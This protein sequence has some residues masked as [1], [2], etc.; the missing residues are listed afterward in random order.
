MNS[1]R[2]YRVFR[3]SHFLS[4]FSC[5]S[6]HS[7]FYK[8]G[9]SLSAHPVPLRSFCTSQGRS[10]VYTLLY[11]VL[12]DANFTFP[13]RPKPS[14]RPAAQTPTEPVNRESNALR[15]SVLDV[16]L[17]LGIAANGGVA[18]WMFNN[19]LEEED[20]DED[21]VTSMRAPLSATSEEYAAYSTP[22]T[23]ISSH[24]EHH[25]NVVAP[26]LQSEEATANAARPAHIHFPPMPPVASTP[27]QANKLRKRR[28]DGYE[29]DGGY[30]SDG[31]K[32]ARARTK[33][34]KNQKDPGPVVPP[35]SEP[36]EMVPLTKEERKR[37][38]KAAKPSSKDHDAPAE[39]DRED[40]PPKP[41]KSKAPP[42][43][44]KKKSSGDAAAGYETDDGYVSSSGKPKSK[45][46]SRFFSLR[47]AKADPAPEPTVVEPVPPMPERELFPLPIAERF[48]TTLGNSSAAP[49]RSTTPLLPPSQPFA[50]TTSSS[51]SASLSSSSNSLLT[52]GDQDS[53]GTGLL[54]FNAN[55][56]RPFED[57]QSVRS[58]H[59]PD[60]SFNSAITVT[61]A[62]YQQDQA[63]S[64]SKFMIS[65]PLT[66]EP[67][68]PSPL[69]SQAGPR[70]TRPVKAKHIPSPI[71]LSPHPSNHLHPGLGSRAPSPSPVGSPF[72]V[73]T[74]INTTG[75]PNGSARAVSPAPSSVVVAS[76]DY[77]VPSRAPS[78]LLPS[79]NVLSS[80]NVLAYYDI[81]PPSPPPN[82]PLPRPPHAPPSATRDLGGLPRLRGLSQ[83]RGGRLAQD[84]PSPMSAGPSPLS[85][86]PSPGSA[87]V[88]RG[89]AAPF[90]TRPVG[91]PRAGTGHVGPG[92]EARAKV[93]RYRDLYAIQIP[94][95]PVRGGGSARPRYDDDEEA[96]V[97]IRVE[98]YDDADE[99]REEMLGVLDRFHEPRDEPERAGSALG[100]ND[101]GVLR[102]KKH[103]RFEDERNPKPML[104]YYSNNDEASQYPDED[105]TAGRATMYRFDH[106]GRDTMYSEY[107]RASFL[108]VEKSEKARDRL[109][110]HVG[111]I[112]DLSGRERSVI[113]PMPKVPPTLLAAG[114]G[115]NRF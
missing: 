105:K 9:F 114:N 48:A 109:V 11:R 37:K 91:Q 83:D 22:P 80:P 24:S 106:G 23:S 50:S 28:G 31:G 5:Y 10:A 56:M 100:R 66:R 86:G 103:T 74:P 49:S 88:Q 12:M 29:S 19:T 67:S 93:E 25:L 72:V 6:S 92:L 68:P 99:D 108:D 2:K 75:S 41:L 34:Q 57:A 60:K 61:P 36:M 46:R 110:E 27:P 7:L 70:D 38:K 59:V 52:P 87:G 4:T 33:S 40:S 81:P 69:A 8:P 96:G 104:E 84:F 42:K 90:P 13:V 44:K 85:A 30:V 65:Y 58:G 45:G 26:F 3:K 82:A 16:A 20:E 21:A 98:E 73:L 97:D 102:P 53:F 94:A 15:A 78:P 18:N 101:S 47:R 107:S 35:I 43:P 113:P 51:S 1:L 62:S 39:T 76:S 17:E 77:I 112:F 71:T 64:R 32:K 95:A 111:A 63:S 14:P 55:G 115:R 89:R 79:P 54:S